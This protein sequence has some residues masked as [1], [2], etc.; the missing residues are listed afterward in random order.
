MTLFD[1]PAD[2]HES[3]GM[4]GLSRITG[5]RDNLFG[6]SVRHSNYIR[7]RI[8]SGEKE[9]GLKH[10]WFRGNSTLIEIDI[11]PTQFADM[12]TAMNVSDGVPCTIRRISVPAEL[13]NKEM[14]PCPDYD[15]RKVFE[16]EF[17]A[18]VEKIAG[19]SLAL[20]E[21]ADAML[22]QKTL[23]SAERD[24]L[25]AIIYKLHQDIKSNLPYVQQQFT[26]AMDKTVS[27]AKGE[28]E[29]FVMNKVTSLGIEG[30]QNL[31]AENAPAIKMIESHENK[32]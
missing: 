23:K 18:D 11:S 10:N 5:G 25:R 2:R 14:E 6:S 22:K 8:K 29:A 16:D 13:N 9:R 17:E 21:K 7:L 30:L 28:V 1:K 3:Y 19:N 15:Q 26:E 32:K 20:L 27:E 31:L 12:I 24:E 4:V